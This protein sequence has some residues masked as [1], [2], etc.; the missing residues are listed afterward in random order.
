MSGE[1]RLASE[2][3]RLRREPR[4]FSVADVVA[5][6]P[7]S[8]TANVD[9][10]EV[11]FPLSSLVGAA[12]LA[13]DRVLV[14]WQGSDP[15]LVGG[16]IG[17]QI[18]GGRE[19]VLVAASDSLPSDKARADVVC[20]GTNDQAV[21]A[22]FNHTAVHLCAGTY[23]IDGPLTLN[24]MHLVGGDTWT[25]RS[26]WA[27]LQQNTRSTITLWAT[28]L[29][30]VQ[31]VDQ[32]TGLPR[33]ASEKF[34]VGFG[35]LRDVF[36][37]SS[38]DMA[39]ET[40]D[41]EGRL[42]YV[43]GAS[44]PV[45]VSGDDAAVDVSAGQLVV[46]G[47]V[48]IGCYTSHDIVVRGAG[49]ILVGC[50]ADS[51][52]VVEAGTTDAWI[53]GCRVNGTVTDLGTGTRIIDG[54]TGATSLAGLTD[55]ADVLSPTTGQALAYNGTEWDAAGI[56][57]TAADV[58]DDPTGRTI[59][60]N[61]DVDANLDDVDVA[62]AYLSS[63]FSMLAGGS[64]ESSDADYTIVLPVRLTTMVSLTAAREVTLP[65]ASALGAVALPV[66]IRCDATCSATNTVTIN[67]DGS[68]TINGAAT[69]VLDTADA[70]ARLV[71]DPAGGNWLTV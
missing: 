59:L 19:Y 66:T 49:P 61:S 43:V 67:P 8:V 17:T 12:P 22:L 28:T 18:T 37:M 33:D 47:A 60:T 21:L 24:A 5:K 2:I 23:Q 10:V 41:V 58:I 27:K 69:L 56:S 63:G 62:L 35:D 50:A 29:E 65:A 4:P 40:V 1:D 52:L 13:G 30:R 32:I 57:V 15:V 51:D 25:S 48:A 34:M 71:V 68:D 16:G 64:A 42:S 26:S 54:D 9:G 3:D 7:S 31:I 55:V 36:L 11:E 38:A 45:V 6:G 46:D 44:G 53:V 70:V 14:A 39:S 20:T